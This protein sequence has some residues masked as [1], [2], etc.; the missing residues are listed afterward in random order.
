M[1]ISINRAELL[2]AAKRA[3]AIAPANSPLDVL[4]GVLLEADALNGTLTLTATNLEIALEQKL[5]CPVQ[6]DDALVINAR[7][8]AGMLEKLPGDAV[9]LWR[10]AAIPQLSLQSGPTVYTAAIWERGSFPKVEIPFP[11]DMVKLSGIPS[12]A[13]R[14]VFA[15]AEEGDKPF[16]KCVSLKF[17]PTGLQAAGSNGKCVITAK[18]DRNSTGNISL[19]IPAPS[20]DKLA[21]MCGNGDEFR[22]G[23]AENNIVFFKENFVY[24]A[25]LVEGSY[26]DT[27]YLTGI[28][29]NSFTVLADVSGLRSAL[30]SVLSVEPNGKV[31]LEFNAQKLTFHCTGVYGNA[32]APMEVISL[33]G[34]PQGQYWYLSRQLSACLRALNGTVTVGIAQSGLLTLSTEDAFYMQSAV[35]PDT[36]Q[37]GQKKSAKK[38]A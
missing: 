22:V 16:L 27:E 20:L 8:L 1:N 18:G 19:L 28:V 3:A 29:Q 37:T 31:M 34:V 38:A 32:A 23:T 25:R 10:E 21:H 26:L 17:T 11:E 30:A 7:L 35:R 33:T 5:A 13:K 12:M 14:T 15:V 2:D 24:S 4:K 6:E 36:A 9:V